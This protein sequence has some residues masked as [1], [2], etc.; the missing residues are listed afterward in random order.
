M[1]A[2]LIHGSKESPLEVFDWEVDR[3]LEDGYRV[4]SYLT[5]DDEL[6]LDLANRFVQS[7]MDTGWELDSEEQAILFNCFLAAK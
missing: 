7:V 5:E 2:V 1:K 6:R 4:L 3:Y